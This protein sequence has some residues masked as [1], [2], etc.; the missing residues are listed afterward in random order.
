MAR[1]FTA[2]DEEGRIIA[3]DTMRGLRFIRK[4]DFKLI[5]RDIDYN[6]RGPCTDALPQD[7][8]SNLVVWRATRG[9]ALAYSDEIGGSAQSGNKYANRLISRGDRYNRQNVDATVYVLGSPTVTRTAGIG[10]RAWDENGNPCFNTND[11]FVRVA[12][13][14][15]TI[16]NG[17]ALLDKYRWNDSDKFS[18]YKT[19]I[20]NLPAGR[21]YAVGIS[22]GMWIG[23]QGKWAGGDML[24]RYCL[25]CTLDANNNIIILN[26]QDYEISYG[27]TITGY[28]R[29][30]GN[31]EVTFFVMDV[32][33]L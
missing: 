22:Q 26:A 24:S 29:N 3:S 7:V 32:T 13:V 2:R 16:V 9:I 11:K 15:K 21:T 14:F 1:Y 18:P 19:I 6:S 20:T 17:E 8:L 23:S 10:A 4:Q 5:W 27:G 33:G 28:F 31:V 30:M 12:G 25:T